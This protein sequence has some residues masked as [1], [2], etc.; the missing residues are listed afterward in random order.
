MIVTKEKQV[1]EDKFLAS[2]IAD[3]A[4]EMAEL[5]L[6]VLAFGDS[7]RP[8]TINTTNFHLIKAVELYDKL[9]AEREI[10]LERDNLSK[11]YERRKD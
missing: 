2:F 6:A 5:K 10:R 3:T 9:K 7:C 11:F 1:L 4:M 8:D